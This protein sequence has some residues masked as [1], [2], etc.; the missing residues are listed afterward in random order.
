V[1]R[2]AL[3]ESVRTAATPGA[4]MA[5]LPLAAE[6]DR[7]GGGAVLQDYVKDMAQ[8]DFAVRAPLAREYAK[9][10]TDGQASPGLLESLRRSKEWDLYFGALVSTGEAQKDAEAL[11]AL[12]R[13]AHNSRDPWLNLVVERERARGEALAGRNGAAEQ[14]LLAT[15]RTCEA[16]DKLFHCAE[17]N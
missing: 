8:R 4:V 16:Y 12:Q 14:T 10:V 15:L 11:K 1:A 17:I 6:L 7:V 3:Y 5:L 9:L 13:F 2:A